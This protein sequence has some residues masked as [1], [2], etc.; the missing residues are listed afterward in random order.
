MHHYFQH[1]MAVQRG[2]IALA[3]KV[4]LL[5][6]GVNS[7]ELERIHSLNLHQM[8]NDAGIQH[9]FYESPCTVRATNGAWHCD[10]KDF[11]LRP[12]V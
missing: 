8:L 4:H 9:V 12:F 2:P 5:W 10:L 7:V 3:K 1:A 6:S 11:L